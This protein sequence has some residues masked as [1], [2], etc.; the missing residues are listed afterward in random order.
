MAQ[1]CLKLNAN[2]TEVVLF[3]NDPTFWNATWWP[4]TLGPIPTPIKKVKN[5]GIYLDDKLSF[6]DQVSAVVSSVS[7]TL[8]ICKNILPF[9]PKECQKTVITAL[10]M[11]K[12]D[13]CNSLYLNI[14]EGLINKLQLLQN[15]AARL[16]SGN[17][18]H[19][20]ISAEIGRLHC[21]PVEKRVQFKALC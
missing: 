19:G 18:K 13:Y 2:K 6:R 20:S 17:P 4:D 12:L 11:S 7:C 16:L 9:L 21:L 3:G 14:Q 5:L 8:K 15:A 1:N 10:A